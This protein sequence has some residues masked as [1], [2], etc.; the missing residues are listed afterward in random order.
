MQ[1]LSQRTMN[2]LQYI[3]YAIFSHMEYFADYMRKRE[4]T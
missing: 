3:E 4:M 1:A 2:Q